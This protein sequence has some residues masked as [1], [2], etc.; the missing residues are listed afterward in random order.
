LILSRV[1]IHYRRLPD[2]EQVFDQLMLEETPDH[3]VTFLDSTEIP[4]PVEVAGRTVLEPGS[5]VIWFT[6]PG[7]WHDL[8]RFHLRDGTF[9]GF[10]ANVLTPVVM[11]GTRWETTDLC[12]DVWLGADGAIEVLDRDD[13]AEARARGWIDAETARRAGEEAE[14]LVRDAQASRWPPRHAHEWDLDRAR[15]R[16]LQAHTSEEP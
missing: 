5:P 10:Y 14:R 6:Y 11:A 16:I 4:G 1:A 8:G 13:F 2:R 9:T 15:R 12:L 3:V 7:L